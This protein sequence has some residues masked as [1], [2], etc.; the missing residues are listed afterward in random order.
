LGISAPA[1]NRDGSYALGGEGQLDG[2]GVL[3]RL[4][5]V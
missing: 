1:A 5:C 3:A 4:E 2:T